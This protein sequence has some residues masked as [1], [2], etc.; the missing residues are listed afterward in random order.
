M[1]SRVATSLLVLLLAGCR[2]PPAEE[3]PPLSPR[4]ARDAVLDQATLEL[5]AGNPR[6]AQRTLER[7]Q[8]VARD[9]AHAALVLSGCQLLGGDH[10]AAI[11]TLRAYLAVTPRASERYQRMIVRLLRHH[12]GGGDLEPLSATEACYF[13]LY[14][15]KALEE[16]DTAR[17]DLA[18]AVREAPAPERDL[19]RLALATMP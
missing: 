18:W 4:E 10:A 13:G 16:P 5:E 19:A 2:A 11:D 1:A 9:R 12:S 14:G 15:L 17:P 6:A 7:G 8:W 3:L